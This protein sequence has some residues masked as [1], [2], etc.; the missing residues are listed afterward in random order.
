MFFPTHCKV[1]DKK[2]GLHYVYSA[3]EL[4]CAERHYNF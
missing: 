2:L 3:I 1:C 4:R